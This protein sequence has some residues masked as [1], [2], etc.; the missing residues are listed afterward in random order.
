MS[1]RLLLRFFPF[2]L[3]FPV[4]STI[5][6]GD[7]IAGITGALVLVPK[8]MAYAQLSGLPLY[9]GLY[10]AFV[11]AILGALWGSSRQLATGPVAIVS[12]MT[13]AAV[14]P[15]ALPHSEEYIGLALLLTLLVGLIQLILGVVKLGSIVNFVSHPVILGFMNA[16]AIIIGLSQIDMLLGI[17]KGRSDF[18]LKDIWEMLR[19]LPQTHLPT[20]AMAIFG[21]I[22]M[23]AMKK[24]SALSKASVLIAVA[25]TTMVSFIIGFE[26]KSSG[27]A[28]DI[29]TPAA[30]ELVAA[31]D[32]AATR[33]GELSA[34]ATSL[35]GQLRQAEKKHDTRL[36]ADLRHQIDLMKLDIDALEVENSKHLHTIR[37][38]YFVRAKVGE[39]MPEVLYLA[40]NIPDKIVTDGRKWHIKKIEHGE[41]QLVGG[42]DVV[43]KVPSG[44]PSFRL[45][46]F[47]LDAVLQLL[48]AA[49][50]ISLVAFMESISMAKAMASKNKQRIDP[51]QELI[52]Q[53]LANIGGSLFQ[54]Y[55]ACGSF[56]GS[57]INLQAGAKT[58]FAMVFNGI[59][60]AA[61]LLFLTPFLYHLPKA[62]LAVII[63][64]AVTGLVTPQALKHTWKAS[65]PDG[66]VALVTFVVTL[67]AAPHLDK[68]IMIGTAL[69]I[70][71]YLYRSRAPRVA[72]LGRHNDGTLRDI[73][74]NPNLT[75]SSLVTAIRF[76][77][78]LYFANISHFE[79]AVLVSVAE[80]K[81]A[82]Y[83]LIVG[84]A[85]NY[86]DSSGEEMIHHLVVQLRES[87]VELV[88]SGLKKQILDVM[89]AT[90]LYNLIGE[91]NIFATEDQAL[92]AISQRLGEE[93]KDD[94]P[95]FHL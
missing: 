46:T 9:Y 78:S 70:G 48:T 45:P 83:L 90:K 71:L 54:A 95:F 3:W 86:I 38:L 4:S 29:V 65:R 62:V 2:L 5:L 25:V 21:L 74:I 30:R 87:G 39:N 20:L 68:G 10:T 61:T 50:I 57:A 75:T 31:Y 1:N 37:R 8:A 53:G 72:V 73:K 63:L 69:S 35:A 16:A 34:A 24:I 19:Y 7:L 28:S 27:L 13:A 82:K 32:D 60:V 91:Q 15:L 26:H 80:H 6:R 64:L 56:T 85:I 36:A 44:L 49:L 11:P 79:D 67:L 47:S 76:D 52:G 93:A 81:K 88:F 43:G 33:I 84:D 89:R 22:L 42:G 12:L 77:G 59:F 66:I 18:F 14:T 23:L 55:P 17:P 51:N 94:T 92:T 40:D 58:G 41:I